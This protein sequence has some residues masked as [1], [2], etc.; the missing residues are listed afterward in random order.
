MTSKTIIR[1]TLGL[2]GLS[3]A[4][5]AIAQAPAA[6]PP[7]AGKPAA[8]WAPPGTP[9]SPIN[10]EIFHAQVLLDVAGFPSGVIDGKKGMVFGKSISGFQ[11]AHNLK[12]TGQFDTPTRQALL[13]Q[14]R[15][16]T[17]MVK[18]SPDQVA[19]PF[20]LPFPK[21]P[22]DQA[23]LQFM[24]Y[25]NMLEEVAEEFHTTP[26]TI[27]ALNGLDAKIGAGATLRLPNVIA[28][29]R[30]YDGAKPDIAPWMA[31]L[32]V[33]SGDIQGDYVVVSKHEGVL[34]VMKGSPP[35]GALSKSDSTG[36]KPPADTG[37]GQVVA[38]FPVT[39]GST[40]DPLPLG[41]WKATTYA[42][43]PPFHYNPA[44]FWDAN[45]DKSEEKL[46]PGPNGPVGLAWLDLTKE[47]YGIHGTGSPETIGR[48]ESHGCIRLSNWDVLRLS[49]M[50]KPGFK[51]VLTS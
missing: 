3:I 51:A 36:N 43:L 50:L 16:S 30:N 12:P 39:M 14:N 11:E 40:H 44:L 13:G 9:G 29:N 8:A 20:V 19:G 5:L 38:Q 21:K 23:K 28:A 18:L 6:Q 37:S 4:A 48:A 34:R 1:S 33:D 46:P 41:L 47:H 17:I 25:R 27:V 24:G 7:S 42:F 31:K 35:Q 45:P 15:P 2:A 22:E 26:D 49:R 32:N 10:G